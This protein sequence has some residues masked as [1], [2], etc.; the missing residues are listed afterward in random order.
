MIGRFDLDVNA[1][2]QARLKR[3]D[4]EQAVLTEEEVRARILQRMK[5]L[6]TTKHQEQQ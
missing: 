5:A 3:W 4:D 1:E 2:A 6:A